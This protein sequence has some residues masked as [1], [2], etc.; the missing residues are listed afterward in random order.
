MLIFGL[1][2]SLIGMG[3]VYFALIL[4]V[5]MIKGFSRISAFYEKRATRAIVEVAGVPATSAVL[6]RDVGAQVDEEIAAVIGAAVAAYRR[7]VN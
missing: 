6:V 4:L 7:D 1:K 3:I 5:Y 2:V